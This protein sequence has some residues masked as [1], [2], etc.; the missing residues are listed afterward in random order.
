[1]ISADLE[2]TATQMEFF[3]SRGLRPSP[4]FLSTVATNLRSLAEQARHLEGA[5][6]PAPAR[7]CNVVAF[8]NRAIAHT[9]GEAS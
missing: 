2:N 5:V 1:M 9:R 6:V 3:Y 7:A 4:E 8:P